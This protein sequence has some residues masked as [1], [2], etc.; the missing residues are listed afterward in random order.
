MANLVERSLRELAEQVRRAEEAKRA[1]QAQEAQQAE[2]AERRRRYGI[3]VSY[4]RKENYYFAG[5]LADASLRVS[6]QIG[7][8]LT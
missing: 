5:W 8:S 7:F 3:F 4:R 1:K 2:E 6:E